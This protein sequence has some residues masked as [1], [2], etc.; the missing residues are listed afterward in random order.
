[1]ATPLTGNN[2]TVWK[3][4]AVLGMIPFACGRNCTLQVDMAV[5]EVTNYQSNNWQEFKPDLMSWSIQVDGL[6]IND[7]YSY[8]RQLRDQKNRQSF[9]FQF[10]MDEGAAGFAIYSGYAFFTNITIQGPQNDLASVSCTLQGTGAYTVSDTPIP[11]NPG[12]GMTTYRTYYEA[13]GGET[14]FVV[15]ALIG[16]TTLLYASRGGIDSTDILTTGT[17]T[18][19]EVKWDSTTGT[20]YIDATNPAIAGEWFNFMYNQ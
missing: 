4:D 9:F 17:P 14:S 3:Q 2:I 1:M 10:I 15:A 6:V 19:A 8:V 18:G 16:A 11:P 12:T 7:D 5:K 20:V 13:T